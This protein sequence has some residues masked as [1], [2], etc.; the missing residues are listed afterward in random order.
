MARE[1]GDDRVSG[2]RGRRKGD[3]ERL[4]TL[5]DAY[6]LDSAARTNDIISVAACHWIT[7]SDQRISSVFRRYDPPISIVSIVKNRVVFNLRSA[8]ESRF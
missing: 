8:I 4:K 7:E 3:E 5:A 6:G 2:N 1:C